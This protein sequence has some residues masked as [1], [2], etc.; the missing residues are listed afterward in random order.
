MKRKISKI[1]GDYSA[2]SLRQLA[3]SPYLYGSDVSSTCYLKHDYQE[4]YPGLISLNTVAGGD[5]E[6]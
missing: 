3:R 6:T 1:L 2:R 5:I 4:R